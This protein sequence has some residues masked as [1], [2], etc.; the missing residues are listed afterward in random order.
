MVEIK[1]IE[2]L[3]RLAHCYKCSDLVEPEDG[4]Y[5]VPEA[6]GFISGLSR[7]IRI[8]AGD[9]SVY[10]FICHK[11]QRK[12]KTRKAYIWGALVLALLIGLIK[13]LI[14]N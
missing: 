1:S 5:M 14:D 7:N 9:E 4:N 2:D 3:N 12:I 8:A 13:N 6:G 11:C 10:K